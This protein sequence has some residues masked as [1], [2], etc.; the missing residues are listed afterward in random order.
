MEEAASELAFE[1]A[2]VLRDQIQSLRQ[3]QDKQYVE[4]NK[5][6]RMAG[7]WVGYRRRRHDFVSIWRW[8]AGAA[9]S[10]KPQTQQRKRSQRA[11]EGIVL[12]S[13]I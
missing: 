6:D 13:I 3:V 9:L 10:D 8:Y 5:G 12:F 7:C 1:Q 4:S 11:S 2:A